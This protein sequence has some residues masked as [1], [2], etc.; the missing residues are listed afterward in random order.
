MDC[1]E[2]S[3]ANTKKWKSKGNREV[4]IEEREANI[5][6]RAADRT[7]PGEELAYGKKPR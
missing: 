6:V 7:K 5:R 3:V 1:R 2:R 4:K